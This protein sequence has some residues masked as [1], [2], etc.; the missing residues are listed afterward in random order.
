MKWRGASS[1]KQQL[2][3]EVSYLYQGGTRGNEGFLGGQQVIS[4]IE[5]KNEFVHVKFESLRLFSKELFLIISYKTILTKTFNLN[6]FNNS[7]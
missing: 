5:I 6:K 4:G 3:T 1:Y 2:N 7:C